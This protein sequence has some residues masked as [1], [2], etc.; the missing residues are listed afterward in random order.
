[1]DVV[2]VMAAYLPMVRVC[3]ALSRSASLDCAVHTHTHIRLQYAAITLTASMS[4]DKIEP[5]L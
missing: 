4:T 2:G 1:M 5:L 3:T